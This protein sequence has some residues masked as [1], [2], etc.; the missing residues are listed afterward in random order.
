MGKYFLMDKIVIILHGH[1][2]PHQL[3]KQAG[4]K[5]TR[6]AMCYMPNGTGLGETTG[7]SETMEK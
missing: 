5:K 6:A 3:M 4:N 2:Y 1:K 7:A